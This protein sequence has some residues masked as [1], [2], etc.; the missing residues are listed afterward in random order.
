MDADENFAAA[1]WPDGAVGRIGSRVDLRLKIPACRCVRA[2]RWVAGLR[3]A[4]GWR[5]VGWRGALPGA[6][7][8]RRCAFPPYAVQ[9]E[10]SLRCGR[11]DRQG[12]PFGD[13]STQPWPASR[14]RPSRLAVEAW[15]VFGVQQLF[16]LDLLEHLVAGCGCQGLGWA[17]GAGVGVAEH[18]AALG[19]RHVL[20]AWILLPVLRVGAEV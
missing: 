16:G 3:G 19:H 18:R 13:P 2:L 11:V 1:G 17:V 12:Q 15:A 7:G 9:A 5:G 10:P 4:C 8:G 14:P 6:V 20:E